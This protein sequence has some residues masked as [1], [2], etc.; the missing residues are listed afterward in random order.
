MERLEKKYAFVLFHYFTSLPVNAKHFSV[1]R[2]VLAR[3][4]THNNIN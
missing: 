2:N 4:S 3:E 1:N